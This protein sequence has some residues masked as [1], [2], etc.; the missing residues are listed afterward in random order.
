MLQQKVKDGSGFSIKLGDKSVNYDEKFR[1]FMTTT[2]TNPHYSPETSVKVTLLNFAITPAGMEDQMLGIA[3]AKERPDLEEAN[4][5]LVVQGAKMNKQ[6]NDI[7]NEIL[8]LLEESE[9]DVLADD[10]LINTIATAKATANEINKKQEEAA[11]TKKE[12]D[13]ARESYR[14]VAFRAAILFFGVVEFA[15]IDPMYQF[16]LQWFQTLFGISV[17]QTEKSDDLET[18]LTYLADH[19][20]MMLYQSVSRG[21][22]EKDKLLFSLALCIRVLDG[23]KK[24]DHTTLRF[25]LTGPTSDLTENGPPK[26]DVEWMDNAMWNEILTASN[27]PAMRRTDF[28]PEEFEKYDADKSGTVELHEHISGEIQQWQNIY[29][30]V[31]AH[32]EAYPSAFNNLDPLEKMAVLRAMRMDKI[33]D[34]V[35]LF[36]ASK[37][38]QKFVEPPTFD[39]AKSYADSKNTIPLVFILS[40]GVDP[41]AD[42][43]E[44]AEKLGM[45]KRFESISLGQGQGPKAARMIE[46]GCNLGG[47]VLL[48]NCHLAASW[49]SSL[50][51]IVEQFNPDQISNQFRLWCTSMPSNDFPVQVLQNGVKMTNEPPKG[52]RAN[53]LRSYAGISDKLFEQ[54]NKPTVFKRL[55]FGFCFF[56][57][58]VQDRRKF[59]PIGWNIQ[60]RFTTE[61][62]ITNRRQLMDF[63]NQYDEPPYKVLNY[64]GAAINY[65][66]RVT[67]DKDKRL[68][69]SILRTYIN[70]ELVE[71][72]S[73]YKFSSSGLYYC[74]EAETCDEF[75]DYIRTLPLVPSP[76]AFGMDSN[77][78]ITCAQSDSMELLQGLLAAS[79]KGAKAG[80][81]KSREDI[82]DETAEVMQKKTPKRFE[83]DVIELRYPTMYE[84]SL[85]TVLKQEALRVNRLALIMVATLKEFRKAIRGLVVMSAELDTL[86]IEM[87]NNQVPEA[88]A[89]KGF[90]SLK[91]LSSWINDFND[92]QIFLQEWFEGGTPIVFWVSGFFFPQA[93]LTGALQNY[94]RKYQIPID[95]ISMQLEV[96]DHVPIDQ[97]KQV[98]EKPAEGV[99]LYGCFIE[100][101]RWDWDEHQLI[102]SRPKELYTDLPMFNFVPTPNR[103]KK[104]GTYDCPLYKV[105]TRKGVLLTTGHSTNF[106]MMLELP[107]DQS[108][109]MWTRAGVASILALKS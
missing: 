47:W 49:M 97:V 1:F 2:L 94:A 80:K 33:T 87:F 75:C 60:Y 107:T 29:D 77:C 90:L 30:C 58:A 39:I 71:T 36:V 45:A 20:T 14:R 4:N 27:L 63:V 100:G 69:E 101:C 40:P 3:V 12:I 23:D 59:G 105:L 25:V 34:A 82:M 56:H 53:L 51:Q 102:P 52:L 70:K 6:L 18:R 44:F 99:Y 35:I 91:P 81:G 66:G 65:G 67:D 13:V 85:N 79:A 5:Q 104:E 76:E 28:T 72:G 92:R 108:P 7:E 15:V 84:E 61:D 19:F 21:L 38:G 8:K 83:I 9:G 42:V 57:A 16:S 78:A 68:I 32:L 74:P 86:G 54:S 93:F 64:L 98:K 96:S 103:V 24:V 106:V 48:A 73:E 95:I 109:D 89:S 55:L 37:I 26:P 31:D 17:D 88:W 22:F 10:T 50:E 46:S 62:L 11:I 43:I 41:T